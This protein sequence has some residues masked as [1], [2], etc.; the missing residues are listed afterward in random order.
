MRIKYKSV[1]GKVH[2]IEVD[3]TWGA[4]I[5]NLDHQESNL[6]RKET[7]RH[8]AIDSYSTN[9]FD[10]ETGEHLSRDSFEYQNLE[11]TDCEE[12]LIDDEKEDD[13]QHIRR[14]VQTLKPTYRDLITAIYFD[15]VSVNDYAERE[16][17]SCSAISHRLQTAYKRLKK[18]F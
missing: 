12:I 6:N 14:L 3:D 17:V 1:T 11:S 18:I 16:G 2:E 5:L 15:G 4:V 7:R 13:Y 8:I 9:D 10:I